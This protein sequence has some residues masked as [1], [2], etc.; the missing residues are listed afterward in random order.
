ML[1]RDVR[2][3]Q[4]CTSKPSTYT[5]QMRRRGHCQ[6]SVSNDAAPNVV[7]PKVPPTCAVLGSKALVGLTLKEPTARPE[8]SLGQAGIGL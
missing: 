8:E 3:V 7:W 4:R 6:A 2:Q 1:V 5:T